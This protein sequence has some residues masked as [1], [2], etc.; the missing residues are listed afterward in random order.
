MDIVIYDVY[1]C[2]ERSLVKKPAINGGNHICR[3]QCGIPKMANPFDKL[4]YLGLCWYLDG[5][6]ETH[7]V[8]GFEKLFETGISSNCLH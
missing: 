7:V 4:H 3:L 8:D 5:V 1:E 6:L 2:L